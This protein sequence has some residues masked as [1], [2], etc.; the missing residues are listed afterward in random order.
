[1][2]TDV[3]DPMT[4]AEAQ[5]LLGASLAAQRRY[6][7]VRP[8]MEAADRILKPIPECQGRD[9]ER[10]ARGCNSCSVASVLQ[11]RDNTLWIAR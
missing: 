5:A 8:L 7:E 6:D 1:M 3:A 10:I 2:S 4:D 11:R 9:R